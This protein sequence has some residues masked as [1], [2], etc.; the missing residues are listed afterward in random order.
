MQLLS[1]QGLATNATRQMTQSL[2][3]TST[4]EGDAHA[5]MKPGQGIVPRKGLPPPSTAFH[6]LLPANRPSYTPLSTV[7]T[8]PQGCGN[9]RH[10]IQAAVGELAP[11]PWMGSDAPHPAFPH[12]WGDDFQVQQSSFAP[13]QL[14]G[15]V[16]GRQANTPRQAFLHS[17]GPPLTGRCR[18]STLATGLCPLLTPAI[19]SELL[20]DGN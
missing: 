19:D 11:H 18:P 17:P 10:P 3:T 7:G 9:P 15:A 2:Q 4:P 16:V 5:H 1:Q 8:H 14:C 13:K 12:F 20:C 6:L